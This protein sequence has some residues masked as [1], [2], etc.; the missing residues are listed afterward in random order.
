M[1]AI[2][3]REF[4]EYFHSF[5]GYIFV[6]VYLFFGGI[7]LSSYNLLSHSA[8]WAY[9]LSDMTII[10]AL[11]IPAIIVMKLSEQRKNEGDRFLALLPIGEREIALGKYFALLGLLA[12]PTAVLAFFPMILGFFGK[13]NYGASYS[14]FLAFLLFGVALTSICYFISTVIKRPAVYAVVS[15]GVLVLL[16]FANILTVLLP[17]G[18]FAAET[19]GYISLF[20]GLDKFVFGIFD[21]KSI[22]YYL[23]TT[24]LFVVLSMRTADRKNKK[25]ST[26]SVISA[27]LVVLMLFVSIGM[28]L[29][30]V[31]YTEFDATESGKYRVSATTKKFLSGIDDEVTIYVLSADGS[32]PQL[33]SYLRRYAESGKNIDVE[34]VKEEEQK[35]LVESYGFS[36]ASVAPY[37]LL[38]CSDKRGEFVDFY[39]M[40]YYVNEKL[41]ITSM[42][43]SDYNYYYSLFSSSESY[44]TYLEALLYSSEL[45][46]H[47]DA[48]ITGA[49]EYVT[50]DIIP[51]AYFI[52]G[53][54]EDSVTD[55]KFVSLLGQMYYDFETHDITKSSGIP[56][57][58]CCI[59]INEPKTDYT[60]S[61]AKIILDYLKSGGRLL[62]VTGEENVGMKNL[63]SITEYYGATAAE[64]LVCENPESEGEDGE[65]VDIHSITPVLNDSHD[66][67][68][69]FKYTLS[70]KNANA[71]T[72][73]EEL[74]KAQLVTPIVTTS[75]NAYVGDE[76]AKA[77]YNLAVA[78][79]EETSQG[80]TRLVWITGADSFNEKESAQNNLAFLV[81]SLDWLDESYTSSV[82]EIKGV[83]FSDDMLNISSGMALGIGVI[84]VLM[85][86]AAVIV[87]GV[88]VISKRRRA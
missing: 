79:E 67:L 15:Y 6:A 63:S 46:F 50:L 29:L 1:K 35:A 32:N 70:V 38:I 37:S 58:A 61:E 48:V 5:T 77:V 64:G 10:L 4:R 17:K 80:T 81:Y 40:Y 57:D 53:R 14:A 62:L 7:L 28:S 74:R 54:G 88:T 34:Y 47:G 72:I 25:I 33:E 76:S 20:G 23:A 75:E 68:A 22:L 59:V 24:A 30:P 71:I 83:K 42:S 18:S 11:L 60:E 39:L 36:N 45:Y 9:A 82:G 87:S 73:S 16:Y 26:I 49:L 69:E 65:D 78:V 31:A 21:L 43:Y 3:K 51:H 66:I 13:V 52:T 86:P 27:M 12:V 56:A 55:G 8:S 19:I 85:I 44:A 84:L 2:L 41:G